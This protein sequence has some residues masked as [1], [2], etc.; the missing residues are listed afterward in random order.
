M[1][2]LKNLG[3]IFFV[4]TEEERY[5]NPEAIKAVLILD[6][7]EGH[8]EKTIDVVKKRFPLAEIRVVSSNR[9][10]DIMIKLRELKNEQF[11]AVIAQSLNPFIIFCVAIS[12]HCY[13][14]IYNRFNQ[15]FL[16]RRK[17]LYEFLA[18]RKGADRQELDWSIAPR[19]INL[20][21]FFAYMLLLPFV[22]AKNI[23]KFI[24]LVLYILFNIGL[25]LLKKYYY[26]LKNV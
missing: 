9:V 21:R 5:V 16:I 3:R 20:A 2:I 17:S 26:Y 7:K 10:I 25:L 22:W 19:R 13:V 24:R 12:F 11:S 4:L 1:K 14:L 8:F 15:W 23:I 6:F 18:G